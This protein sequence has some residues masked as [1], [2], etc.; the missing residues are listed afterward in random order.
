MRAW[1]RNKQPLQE[2][3]TPSRTVVSGVQLRFVFTVLV[4]YGT[5]NKRLFRRSVSAIQFDDDCSFTFS[6]TFLPSSTSVTYISGTT[7]SVST[8]GPSYGM[9]QHTPPGSL[10]ATGPSGSDHHAAD[11]EDTDET[12][13]DDDDNDALVRRNPRRNRR[14]PG[15]GTGGHM[16]H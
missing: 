14:A 5:S 16:R 15:C 13:E 7:I 6:W 4:A 9:V 2:P 8:Q 12:E 1:R 3:I 11:D 10:L